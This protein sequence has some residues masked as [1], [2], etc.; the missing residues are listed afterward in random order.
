MIWHFPVH[1]LKLHR[2]WRCATVPQSLNNSIPSPQGKKLSLTQASCRNSAKAWNTADKRCFPFQRQGFTCHLVIRIFFPVRSSSSWLSPLTHI[3]RRGSQFLIQKTT[4]WN[5]LQKGL[6]SC[7][8]ALHT[9]SVLLKYRFCWIIYIFK[10][11]F[12]ISC[13]RPRNWRGEA[14]GCPS[15]SYKQSKENT[16]SS[17]RAS[18]ALTISSVQ[19]SEWSRHKH[20]HADSPT[21]SWIWGQEHPPPKPLSGTAGKG[22]H[23]SPLQYLNLHPETRGDWDEFRCRDS[24]LWNELA[25]HLSLH[26]IASISQRKAEGCNLHTEDKLSNY[27]A[28][29]ACSHCHSEDHKGLIIS[30]YFHSHRKITAVSLPAFK[31]QA[32]NPKPGHLELFPPI[33]PAWLQP[34]GLQHLIMFSTFSA[35]YKLQVIPVNRNTVQLSL[36][37]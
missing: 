35:I 33:H 3:S 10:Y 9:H 24:C 19:L 7:R 15:T 29:A 14:K 6:G 23:T 26:T 18:G 36:A 1:C 11:I 8:C 25:T 20:C 27:P 2:I 22:N 16:S 37:Q 12:H 31:F 21:S 28:A 30:C 32:L 13:V 4:T 5:Q 17:G 34:K